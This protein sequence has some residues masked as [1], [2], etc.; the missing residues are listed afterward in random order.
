[1]WLE[2]VPAVH[3]AKLKITSLLGSSVS[4]S[5]N[6]GGS[7]SSSSSKKNNAFAFKPQLKNEEKEEEE[8][9]MNSNHGVFKVKVV[10]DAAPPSTLDPNL[11]GGEFGDDDE[12]EED[13]DDDKNSEKKKKYNQFSSADN[14]AYGLRQRRLKNIESRISRRQLLDG[15]TEVHAWSKSAR[16]HAEVDVYAA[17]QVGGNAGSRIKPAPV[18]LDIL[19]PMG[20]VTRVEGDHLLIVG[21][22]PNGQAQAAGIREGYFI[23]KMNNEEVRNFNEVQ[24]I[25][26]KLKQAYVTTEKVPSSRT[27]SSQQQHQQSSSSGS[28]NDLVTGLGSRYYLL[29]VTPTVK[30]GFGTCSFYGHGETPLA[31]PSQAD[32]EASKLANLKAANSL[33]SAQQHHDAPPSKITGSTKPVLNKAES[34][35]MKAASQGLAS[36]DFTTIQPD[37]LAGLNG[38]VSGISGV[39]DSELS[40]G[41]AWQ[42]AFNAAKNNNQHQGGGNEY[43]YRR[44]DECVAE[45][46]IVSPSLWS[47]SSPF[48]YD[49]VVRL[50]HEVDPL[51]NS[52]K[53]EENDGK[54]GGESSGQS[55]YVMLDEVGSYGAMRTISRVRGNDGHIRFVLNGQPLFMLG[56][57]DQGWWP[58]GLLTPPSDAAQVHDIEFIKA[59]GYNT[60]RKHAKV[61]NRRYYY[62]CDRLGMLVWQD[63]VSADE[64]G[65]GA[66]LLSPKHWTRLSKDRPEEGVWSDADHAQ[67]MGEFEA[68]VDML[69]NHPC[70]IIWV[71]CAVIKIA[72]HTHTHSY[73]L[74]NFTVVYCPHLLIKHYTFAGGGIKN[75]IY[76]Y[77]NMLYQGSFQ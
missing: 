72:L 14:G 61:E 62:H 41:G 60:I 57:L 43:S 19:E 25:L 70:I 24:D 28:K 75:Y 20:L 65:R 21:I 31:N 56:I 15:N 26:G 38:G 4:S 12:E 8:N 3:I 6:N 35:Y 39:S 11:G 48:L 76:I 46:S 44:K 29:E 47:P 40:V 74:T 54:D 45:V 30:V 22:K 63:Q 64:D 2:A 66:T 59:S 58:D 37:I 10:L 53:N 9:F 73:I 51:M 34:D 18:I 42:G 7:G 1:V 13:D 52:K 71:I 5:T 49:F 68:M 77:M 27:S 55:Q 50:V 67:F 36:W 16:L 69:E 17:G 32:I 23:S 33:M